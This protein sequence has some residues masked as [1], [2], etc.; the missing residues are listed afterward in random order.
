MRKIFIFFFALF[1]LFTGCTNETEQVPK[2]SFDDQFDES[3]NIEITPFQYIRDAHEPDADYKELK[4]LAPD[5]GCGS[6]RTDGKNV[7]FD[8]K[9]VKEIDLE[10]F[11]LIR[12][13][14]ITNSYDNI[15][16]AYDKN[17]IY[18]YLVGGK[19]CMNS[20]GRLENIDKEKFE[21]LGDQYVLYDNKVYY[22]GKIDDKLAGWYLK[23]A[24]PETFE[25]LTYTYAKD[26]NHIYEGGEVFDLPDYDSFI[27]IEDIH[28]KDKNNCYT[29]DGIDKTCYASAFERYDN[30]MKLPEEQRENI[31]NYKNSYCNTG[32][33]KL[34]YDD[35][36][37]Y[38][39]VREYNKSFNDYDGTGELDPIEIK[40]PINYDYYLVY[41]KNDKDLYDV[42][43]YYEFGE[44]YENILLDQSFLENASIQVTE[45]GDDIY[46]VYYFIETLGGHMY[47]LYVST[48][49]KKVL[50][51]TKKGNYIETPE[52]KYE[53]D[54]DTH[55]TTCDDE[56]CDYETSKITV[57][58]GLVYDLPKPIEF[59]CGV[60]DLCIPPFLYAKDPNFEAQ[61]VI[62]T[63][64]W[65]YP[66]GEPNFEVV[67]NYGTGEF[68]G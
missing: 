17:G 42:S 1:L 43:L 36:R 68:E 54:Y 55:K 34:I 6:Y 27:T 31:E 24:D 58:D 61:T 28:G 45:E 48:K 51:S 3:K 18:W 60:E 35:G 15:N 57:E 25:V 29:H 13:K 20:I 50:L 22:I 21:Y 11:G 52:I 23:L 53:L 16:L 62:L 65:D 7:Y 49:E 39:C 33:R 32:I 8:G 4:A 67:F 38:Y 64:V 26:K 9:L 14:K 40:V 46:R 5:Y 66:I 59:T 2:F 10:S 56:I 37:R 41:K 44:F 12:P 47:D 30:F 63:D 19:G